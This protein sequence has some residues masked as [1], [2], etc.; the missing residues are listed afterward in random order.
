VDVRLDEHHDWK[1]CGECQKTIS[2]VEESVDATWSLN[3]TRSPRHRGEPHFVR[4]TSFL[5]ASVQPRG[6]MSREVA[7][8]PSIKDWL[9]ESGWLRTSFGRWEAASSGA[10]GF[11][12]LPGIRPSQWCPTR[13]DVTRNTKKVLIYFS[14]IHHELHHIIGRQTVSSPLFG[15]RSARW[16][17]LSRKT[18][19]SL[20]LILF[21]W[22]EETSLWPYQRLLSTVTSNFQRLNF[23][24][25]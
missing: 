18:G 22:R 2:D 24:V 9:W 25:P 20:D 14:E 15:R 21:V 10:T 11:G 12:L 17:H 16:K 3:W 8:N 4:K 23:S 19:R 13:T 6:S 7:P 5:M 1:S